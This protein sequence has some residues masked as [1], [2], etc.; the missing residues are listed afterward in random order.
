MKF[1]HCVDVVAIIW[2]AWIVQA[3]IAELEEELEAERAARTKVP[4]TLSVNNNNNSNNLYNKSGYVCLF[5]C[6]FRM[7]GQTARPIET[8]LDT[9]THVHPGSVSGKVNVKVIHA[10]VRD[11]QK[12]E[13]P[14]MRHLAND[15]ETPSNYRSSNEARRRAASGA[16]PS[17]TPSGGRVIR[18]SNNNN[19]RNI[20]QIELVVHHLVDWPGVA[21]GEAHSCSRCQAQA[22]VQGWM[23]PP[24]GRER[25]TLLVILTR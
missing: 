11:W 6:L 1:G 15:Y 3:R 13:T 16:A 18:A 5:V 2:F 7:A 22:V 19:N 23:F 21:P 4:V 17:R 9:R 8:K 14:R 25:W 12:Y 24:F 20:M 10:C